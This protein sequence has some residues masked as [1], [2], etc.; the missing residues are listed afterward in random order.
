[1]VQGEIEGHMNM[2]TKQKKEEKVV[3]VE[4]VEYEEKEEVFIGENSLKESYREQYEEIKGNLAPDYS[5]EDYLKE[6][7]P[8]KTTKS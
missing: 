8:Y 6:I 2:K 1:M 3:K 7:W 5:F 4:K